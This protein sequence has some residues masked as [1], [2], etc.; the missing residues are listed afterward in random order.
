V[1][2]VRVGKYKDKR[3]AETVARRLQQEEQFNPW[4]TR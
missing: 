2:R 1:Y 3:E 4:I